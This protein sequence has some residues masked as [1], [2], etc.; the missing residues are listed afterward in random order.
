M[1]TDPNIRESSRI[2][3]ASDETLTL[4]P[5]SAFVRVM[6]K[7]GQTFLGSLIT[8]TVRIVRKI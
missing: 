8:L 6:L 4:A 1:V 3:I 7:F 5:R 2:I